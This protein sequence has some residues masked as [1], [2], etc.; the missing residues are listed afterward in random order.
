MLISKLNTLRAANNEDGFTLIELMIVVVIIGI[1]AAVAIPVFAN[2]QKTA[3]G[4]SLKTDVKNAAT[5]VA[6]AL[7]KEPTASDVA[8]LAA[9][10][11]SEGNNLAISGGWD[12]YTIIGTNADG[13]PSC[14]QFVSTTG[15]YGPCFVPAPDA[16]S[17][18]NEPAFDE[19]S[20]VYSGTATARTLMMDGYGVVI[21]SITVAVDENGSVRVVSGDLIRL[22]DT[23]FNP[24]DPVSGTF[25]LRLQIAGAPAF[26][27][28]ETVQLTVANGQ[29][30]SLGQ[31]SS[32]FV[33]VAAEGGN[34]NHGT[35]YVNPGTY[36]FT[37]S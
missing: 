12:D 32:R 14:W 16:G 9:P 2:Q 11:A 3:I 8:L 10:V 6:T 22:T 26:A 17:E 15:E 19:N 30:T 21:P 29:I 33:E 1:L 25:T 4:S 7:I 24:T 36:G 18:P 28:D 35:P 31:V 37:R 20:V 5:E 27:Q 34:A 23:A 13:D